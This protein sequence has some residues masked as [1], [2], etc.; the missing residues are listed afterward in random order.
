MALSIH[1]YVGLL[2]SRKTQVSL[3]VLTRLDADTGAFG[4]YRY[5]EAVWLI[6]EVVE[7]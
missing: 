1:P 6:T 5:N 4:A 2:M 7:R 3:V